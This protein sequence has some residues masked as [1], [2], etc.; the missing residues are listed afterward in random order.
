MIWIV[1]DQCKPAPY[2]WEAAEGLGVGT[3]V[4]MNWSAFKAIA[5]GPLRNSRSASMV[6][7][8]RWFSHGTIS[9]PQNGVCKATDI[10]F[11]GLCLTGIPRYGCVKQ[12]EPQLG[13]GPRLCSTAL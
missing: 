9:R 13:Y 2:I 10:K 8:A 4:L 1:F 3:A 12:T 6:G 5:P 11:R 7:C